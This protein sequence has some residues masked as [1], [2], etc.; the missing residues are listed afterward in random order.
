M[1]KSNLIDLHIGSNLFLYGNK[2]GIGIR[3]NKSLIDLDYYNSGDALLGNVNKA[4]FTYS[5]L[6]QKKSYITGLTY[7]RFWSNNSSTIQASN[8]TGYYDNIIFPHFGYYNNQILQSVFGMSIRLFMV[9]I[10]EDD[11]FLTD[12]KLLFEINLR[13]RIVN[14]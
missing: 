12:Y 8:L 9:P 14:K 11:F 1:L 4:S 13:L 3:V 6:F 10:I 5:Y 7:M 2:L